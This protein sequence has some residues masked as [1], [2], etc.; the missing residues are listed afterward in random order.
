MSRKPDRRRRILTWHVHGNYLFYLVQSQKYDFYAPVKKGAPLGYAGFAPGFPWPNNVHE[1][2]AEQVRELKLDGI[3]FQSRKN[4][5]HDQFE[6]LSDEQRKLPRIYLEH[7][8]PLQHPTDSCHWVQDENILIV[9]VT[10]FNRLMWNCGRTPTQVIQHG[11]MVPEDV[12]YT[13]ELAKGLV[14]VNNIKKRG[15]RLGIDVF[16]RAKKTVPLDL[17]GLQSEACGGLGEI[18][19]DTLPL[20][21]SRY[22][23]FF[24]PIRYTSLGLAI[25]EAM[26]I[27]LPV[28]GLATTELATVIENGVS[29]YIDTDVDRLVLTM[30]ELLA[31]PALAQEWGKGAKRHAEESFNIKRFVRDWEHAF[32]HVL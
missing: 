3:L 31:Y 18:L 17:I 1:V 13:G 25:C 15:R 21:E 6:I 16:E 8:P 20:F 19:H 9:H 10:H 2:P 23:F 14:V 27:G 7:D 12:F 29:G 24:N 26:M 32:A 11:V 5:E 30:Q 4:Y 22:R 28:V